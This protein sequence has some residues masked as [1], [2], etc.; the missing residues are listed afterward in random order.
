MN[1]LPCGVPTSKLSGH[2]AIVAV[3]VYA[4]VAGGSTLS[5]HTW[6]TQVPDDTLE[7]PQLLNDTAELSAETVI[8]GSAIL[9]HKV[10]HKQTSR[11]EYGQIFSKEKSSTK[12][13]CE[14]LY[15]RK[16][17][18]VVVQC[19]CVLLRVLSFK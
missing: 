1:V 18:G 8:T 10:S 7:K 17:Y 9:K 2:D 16:M 3:S 19:K 15:I 14:G 5:T 6:M 13:M 4:Y 11:Q 12:Q